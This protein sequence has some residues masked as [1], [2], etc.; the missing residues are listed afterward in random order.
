MRVNSTYTQSIA[1]SAR[2]AGWALVGAA[3]YLLSIAVAAAVSGTLFYVWFRLDFDDFWLSLLR[4]LCIWAGTWV[5]VAA[6]PICRRFK[7]SGVLVTAPEQP[8][9]FERVN[10]V[11]AL[12]GQTGPTEICLVGDTDALAYHRGGFMRFRSKHGMMIGLPLLHFLTLSELDAIVARELAYFRGGWISWTSLLMRYLLCFMDGTV[13][14]LI[15]GEN[16]EWAKILL[17][18]RLFAA[19]RDLFKRAT[20]PILKADQVIAERLA[21]NT[22]GSDVYADAVDALDYYEE[23]FIKYFYGEVVPAIE[24]GFLPPFMDGFDV[25]CQNTELES[26]R[27]SNEKS[28]AI[29]L[30]INAPEIERQ[31]LR[32]H[33]RSKIE[34]LT[35]ITWR[36]AVLR[37]LLPHWK[38]ECRNVAG[39]HDL[40]LDRLHA[41]VANLDEF[42]KK[43]WTGCSSEGAK[44]LLCAALSCALFR[45]GWWIDHAPGYLRMRCGNEEIDPGRLIE[46]M[47]SPE[48]T[49]ERWQETM[50][51]FD[52]DPAMLL[53]VP[54]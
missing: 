16:F 14:M 41:T 51:Y 38:Y 42:T 7:P 53:G 48:F 50:A 34:K 45:Q 10:R 35:P 3:I 22:I 27:G 19:F 29:S 49:A 8:K 4:A 54:G 28:R 18:P 44:R 36:G 46:E 13:E 15:P 24:R 47:T 30:L 1:P 39:L 21:M 20:T 11:A 26:A 37:V 31:S 43:L 17:V 6:L 32:S 23:P 33:A 5:I 9:L 52:L 40:T 25:Y 12:L 2:L